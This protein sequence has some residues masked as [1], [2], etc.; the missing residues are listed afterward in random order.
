MA[1]G[2]GAASN[3][4]NGSAR[5]EHSASQLAS[6]HMILLQSALTRAVSGGGDF[7]FLPKLDHLRRQSTFIV[8]RNVRDVR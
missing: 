6:S 2:S 3:V 7:V 5:N 1:G 8:R 4:K